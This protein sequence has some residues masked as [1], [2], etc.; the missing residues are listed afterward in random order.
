MENEEGARSEAPVRPGE[1]L[2]AA[3]EQAGLTIA[4]VALRLHL[5]VAQIT[6]LEEGR[7]D[8]LPPAAYVRG[9]L[10]SYAQMLGLDPQEFAKTQSTLE[11]APVPP[12]Q[13]RAHPGGRQAP[14]L[15]ALLYGVL[16]AGIVGAAVVWHGHSAHRHSRRTAAMKVAPQPSGVLPPRLQPLA[17]AGVRGGQIRTFPLT[18]P[19]PARLTRGA[20][21]PPPRR[22]RPH[23]AA[24]PSAPVRHPA[25]AAI[26]RTRTLVAS[27]PSAQH[28]VVSPPAAAPSSIAVPSPGGLVSLP[29]GHHY[30]G[31]RITA[32][33][34]AVRVVV[35]DARGV[36]L[37]ATRIA[38]G[39]SV[40]LV[41]RAPF[42]VTLSASQGVG[43][44][45]AGHA[46]PVP[47][48]P[49]GQ[50]VRVTVDP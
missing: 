25:P 22:V 39:R 27:R 48:A 13:A 10:R 23:P 5:S 47:V 43:I 14:R 9:Y 21:P 30:V 50:N 2:R 11:G 1:R 40:R 7:R 38:G 34:R 46:V 49:K 16:L 24:A 8:S 42:R 32:S 33:S 35:H 28:A 41:G 4:Q 29:Q 44:R 12:R 3:R 17:A 26:P 45:V 6:A 36:R 18:A 15:G 37:L 31:L 19:R 20:L